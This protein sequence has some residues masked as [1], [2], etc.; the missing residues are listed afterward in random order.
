MVD[1][2]FEEKVELLFRSISNELFEKTGNEYTIRIKEH[3]T[4]G[5]RRTNQE[6][7]WFDKLINCFSEKNNTLIATLT[8]GDDNKLY[9]LYR[10]QRITE[11]EKDIIS[12]YTEAFASEN[13]LGYRKPFN[14]SFHP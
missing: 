13:G 11:T 5:Y 14:I 12:R 7:G 10:Q 2:V 8:V 9:L 3:N 4:W 1:V 6:M